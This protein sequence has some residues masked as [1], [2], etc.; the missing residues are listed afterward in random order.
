MKSL[1]ALNNMLKHAFWQ[2]AS[3]DS[4]SR[5]E[6]ILKV[7][8]QSLRCCNIGLHVLLWINPGI[9][10]NINESITKM[11][12]D[13]HW[14]TLQ[15]RRK[16]ARLILHDVLNCNANLTVPVHCLPPPSTLTCTRANHPM[17]YAHLQSNMDIYKYSFLPRTI[18]QWNNLQIENI[19]TLTLT[20][21]KE[22]LQIIL[23][24]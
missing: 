8:Y 4:Q 9:D 21:F 17:K 23:N 2:R 15:N 22:Q 10:N 24:L 16:Q 13:L 5:V 6:I 20:A 18:P 1:M 7:M 11:L 12:A 19:K 14:P 3:N